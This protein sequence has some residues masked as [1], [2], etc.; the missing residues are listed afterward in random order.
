MKEYYCRP[1]RMYTR[2]PD[3]CAKRKAARNNC[4]AAAPGPRFPDCATCTEGLAPVN[5]REGRRPEQLKKEETM[6]RICKIEGCSKPAGANGYCSQ[7]WGEKIAAAR[8]GKKA[9]AKPPAKTKST[10]GGGRATSKSAA[11]QEVP[12]LTITGKDALA[13]AAFCEKALT[14][15]PD[16]RAAYQMLIGEQVFGAYAREV[17]AKQKEA[18]K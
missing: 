5:E 14:G 2:D 4:R 9:A 1:L 12:A 3:L 10:A 15:Q 8:K 7:H 18:A 17:I 11:K 6:K 16:H 13:V